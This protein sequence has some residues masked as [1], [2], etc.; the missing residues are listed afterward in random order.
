MLGLA[1]EIPE[2][3]FTHFQGKN[4]VSLGSNLG[5]S[6]R[7]VLCPWAVSGRNC[8]CLGPRRWGGCAGHPAGLEAGS[9][10]P[11]S[12]EL[13]LATAT[14]PPSGRQATVQGGTLQRTPVPRHCTPA[15]VTPCDQ[16]Q[17]PF[18]VSFVFF[19][20]RTSRPVYIRPPRP[21]YPIMKSLM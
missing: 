5:T 20:R 11:V 18:L 14:V 8:L 1:N 10:P 6:C 4:L 17:L 2:E 16:C 7:W 13:A 3:E 15:S 12:G 21:Y 19:L 9:V